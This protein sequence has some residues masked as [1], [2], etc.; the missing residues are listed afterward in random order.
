MSIELHPI[1]FSVSNYVLSPGFMLLA[2]IVAD[3]LKSL[4]KALYKVPQSNYSW[5]GHLPA[6]VCILSFSAYHTMY[7]HQ[8]S[9]LY[10][11]LQRIYGKTPSK[12]LNQVP[13]SI[14]SPKGHLSVISCILSFSAYRN[15]YFHKVS[16]FYCF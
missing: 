1:I 9:C 16:C 10:L 4:S 6:G 2:C 7:F 14:Y 13:L 8:V 11:V 5:R 12:S 15:I 3:L